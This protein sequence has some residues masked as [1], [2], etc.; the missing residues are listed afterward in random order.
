MLALWTY[1][2]TTYHRDSTH[3]LA[4]LNNFVVPIRTLLVTLDIYGVCYCQEQGTVMG[5]K[6]VPGSADIY[7]G[8]W[9]QERKLVNIPN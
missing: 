8:K 3:L 7:L 6:C 1:Y 9:V 2:H 4:H 5:M